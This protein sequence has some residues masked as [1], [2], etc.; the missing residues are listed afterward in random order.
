M[1]SP[2]AAAI[3]SLGLVLVVP[4]VARAE[5][6]NT[7]QRAAGWAVLGIGGSIGLGSVATG[8]VMI[9]QDSSS[10]QQVGAATLVGG[11]VTAVVGLAVGLPLILSSGG[12]EPKRFDA[13]YLDALSGRFRW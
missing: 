12:S 5:D 2:R 1:R 11:A 13:R 3:V 9:N 7:S 4:T 8:I 6:S 10:N